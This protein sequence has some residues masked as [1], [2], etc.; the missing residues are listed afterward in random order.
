[1]AVDLATGKINY[2]NPGTNL[3]GSAFTWSGWYYFDTFANL[4]YFYHVQ[5]SGGATFH[6]YGRAISETANIA[7][8]LFNVPFNTG[9]DSWQG[10]ATSMPKNQWV[11]LLVTYTPGTGGAGFTVYQDG[12]T[13]AGSSTGTGSGGAQALDGLYTIGGRNY[14]TTRDIDARVHKC[15]MWSRVLSGAEIASLAAGAS[16]ASITSGL[17]FSAPLDTTIDAASGAGTGTNATLTDRYPADLPGAGFIFDPRSASNTITSGRLA[18]ASD[19]SGNGND[20]TETASSGFFDVNDAT[21]GIA[22]RHAYTGVDGIDTNRYLGKAT[23]AGAVWNSRACTIVAIAANHSTATN[24]LQSLVQLGDPA[25]AS[26]AVVEMGCDSRG[27]LQVSR[28]GEANA[29]LSDRR[30]S[31]TARMIAVS[32]STTDVILQVDDVRKLAGAAL[33]AATTTGMRIGMELGGTSLQWD[34]DIYYIAVF[35]RALSTTELDAIWAWG[36]AIWGYEVAVNLFVYEGTSTVRGFYTTNGFNFI[37]GL[38][39]F[40]DDAIVFNFATG[41]E[42]SSNIVASLSATVTH[43]DTLLGFDKSDR[44]FVYQPHGGDFGSIT[45]ATSQSNTTTILDAAET[46]YRKTTILVPIVRTDYAPDTLEVDRE[47][48]VISILAF[49]GARATG[50]VVQ[51]PAEITPI[52]NLSVFLQLVTTSTYYSGDEVHL[53]QDGYD[54]YA[55]PS[56]GPIYDALLSAAAPEFATR[57]G[58]IR[59]RSRTRR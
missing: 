49:I 8:L 20:V 11:H 46:N 32:C 9:N 12:A 56:A 45:Y 36:S 2:A 14:D 42:T 26:S 52:S 10:S 54:L 33:A 48:D 51:R 13:V 47:T 24:A 3:S 18:T 1:M 27:K 25:T 55:T 57:R 29:T 6:F 15:G 17:V 39:H 4:G 16:P 31:A 30:C 53:D 35:Q 59:S 23:G 34:G 41:A 5:K 19:R 58:G 40:F 37:K 22:I 21:R 28:A 44:Y 43:A 7:T 50:G 38:G